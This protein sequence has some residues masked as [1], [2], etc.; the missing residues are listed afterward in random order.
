[1]PSATLLGLQPKTL[2]PDNLLSFNHQD[3]FTLPPDINEEHHND[4]VGEDERESSRRLNE[5]EDH[6]SNGGPTVTEPEAPS[7][8]GTETN[9]S[10]VKAAAHHDVTSAGIRGGNLPHDL[11]R[12]N[13]D[14]SRKHFR[15]KRRKARSDQTA[16]DEG[17]DDPDGDDSS[18][19]AVSPIII[20]A[21]CAGVLVFL[22]MVTGLA[23]LWY[24][25][26]DS[27]IAS[28]AIIG[29]DRGRKL[30]VHPKPFVF[31][32]GDNPNT[33]NDT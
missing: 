24:V 14:V 3:T 11:G 1:M 10:S 22:C 4:T 29:A 9:N 23:C 31:F 12:R 6:S 13:D 8:K 16:E 28:F 21:I 32:D 7:H 25:F 27:S 5:D 17:S 30:E 26:N 20:G 19:E 18:T 15:K 2:S 33:E